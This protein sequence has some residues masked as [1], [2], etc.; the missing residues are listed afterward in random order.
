MPPHLKKYL[1]QGEGVQLDFKQS[2]SSAAK[3]AKT[4]VSFANTR[5][6]VLLIGVRDNRSISGVRSEEEKYMLDMAAGFYCKP[7]IKLDIKEWLIDGK[8]VL[9]CIVPDGNNKPYSAK[10]EEGKWWVYVR[11]LDKS[12]LASKTTLDFLRRS[13]S[14]TEVKLNL[15]F[16]ETGILKYLSEN[17]KI[18]L[19][20]VCRLFNISRRRASRILVDLMSVGVIQSHTFE[21]LEFYTLR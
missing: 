16:I 9:E 14:G 7:E 13:S 18:T 12:L 5:G 4:M 11:S 21:K 10:D 6:G 3:I 8:T 15:G 1:Q 17:D 20:Q 19:P 2:V